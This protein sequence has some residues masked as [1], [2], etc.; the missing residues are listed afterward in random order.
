MRPTKYY[1]RGVVKVEHGSNAVKGEGTYWL[2]GIGALP[3]DGFTFTTDKID[4]YIIKEI[5]ED[6]ALT[7]D[8][9]YQSAS[10]KTSYLIATGKTVASDSPVGSDVTALAESAKQSAKESAESAKAS[11]ESAASS[12]ESEANALASELKAKKWAEED[13]GVPVETGMYSAKHHAIESLANATATAADAEAA[14]SAKNEA[15]AS[16]NVTLEKAAQV[17]ADREAVNGF[18]ADVETR[19]ADVIARQTDVKE[20][21]ANVADMQANTASLAAQV[22]GDAATVLQDKNIVLAAKTEVKAAEANVEALEV[23]TEGHKNVAAAE[24]DASEAAKTAALAAK[25][26]AELAKAGANDALDL[27]VVAKETALDAARRAENSAAA[28][29]GA[30]IEMGGTDLS[31]GVAPEPLV[32]ANGQKRSSFWK[33]V[34]AG[35][36]A[37]VEYGVGDSIVYTLSTDS[38]Y[39]IDNTESVTSVNGQ[40]GVVSITP[41]NIGA[42]KTSGGAISGNLAVAGNVSVGSGSL[43]VEGLAFV[44]VTGA[45]VTVG[46]AGRSFNISGSNLTINNTHRI[47]HQGNLPTINDVVGALSVDFGRVD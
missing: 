23:E 11:A 26:G 39:K 1:Q 28:M 45:Q 7:L 20:R 17:A 44:E 30:M 34:G 25:A 14:V 47:F 32:D 13:H 27:A 8:K 5:S 16:K 43:L 19:Q 3:K 22:E 12:G 37:G 42:L 31:S 21:Q 9:P 40:Q 33:V 6:G 24:A 46:S 41:E 10:R 2:T 36:V 29:T 4:Y 15:V 38:Y 18:R 35:V